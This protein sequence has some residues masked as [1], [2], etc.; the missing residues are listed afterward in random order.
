M[1]VRTKFTLWLV[2][3]SLFAASLFSFFVIHEV[4]EEV[5]EIVDFELQE[6]AAAVFKEIE[7]SIEGFRQF[8]ASKSRFPLERYWIRI[9][10]GGNQETV[11]ASLLSRQAE[12]S[13]A[14]PG[15]S[16]LL[17]RNISYEHIWVPQGEQEDIDGMEGDEVKL[18]ARLFRKEIGGEPVELLVARPLL[19]LVS[20]I[21][22]I[23]YEL[24]AGI[25]ITMVVV[26]IVAYFI[27]GRMLGPLNRVN[28]EIREIRETSLNKRIPLGKSRDELYELS[29]ELNAM[30]DRLQF[31]FDKQREFI[32]NASHEMKSPLTI[33]ILGHEEM[34]MADLPVQVRSELE[35]QLGTM[36]RLNKLIRDLL[37]I[38]RLEQHD[39]LNREEVRVN[40]LLDSILDDYEDLIKNKGIKVYADYKPVTVFADYEKLHRL[41]INLIDN[42]IKYN[43]E[44]KGFLKVELLEYKEYV[45][46][47]ITNAGKPIPEADLSQIFNQFYRVEKSR[48]QEFGG[49]GL[50]LTI[51][52]RITE[53]H[54]GTIGVT[55][56]PEGIMF[57][58]NLPRNGGGQK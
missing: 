16:Y 43:I 27:S 18:Q 17:T 7:A 15:K 1:K 52:K 31:S 40:A 54:N 11:Y 13:V 42:G 55:N 23:V 41:F 12:I 28:K 57:T 50:G 24:T 26:L 29:V 8:D 21:H 4:K 25:I 37:S 56:G 6:L 53:M 35:A 58:V 5:V 22:E 32:G 48:S 51:A 44:D 30:F 3:S 34:L 19:L 33:L 9:T 10:R 36:H 39:V 38:S 47:K 2:C 20:E 45:Q 46:V 49:S 14:G